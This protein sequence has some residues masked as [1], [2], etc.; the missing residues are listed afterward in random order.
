LILWWQ[1]TSAACTLLSILN[2]DLKAWFSLYIFLTI[3]N[4]KA[5]RTLLSFDFDE[6]LFLSHRILM[7][8]ELFKNRL[9]AYSF[10]SIWGIPFLYSSKTLKIQNHIKVLHKICQDLICTS[11]N[12]VY[13]WSNLFKNSEI[14]LQEKP[15]IWCYYSYFF[16]FL[17]NCDDTFAMPHRHF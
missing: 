4:R 11:N 9:M 17:Q 10:K 1:S 12:L 14:L 2:L 16:I 13:F 8:F 15:F 7:H 6:I 5:S 3:L